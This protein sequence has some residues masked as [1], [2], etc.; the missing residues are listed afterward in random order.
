MLKKCQVLVKNKHCEL[1]WVPAENGQVPFGALQGGYTNDEITV[2]IGRVAYDGAT[3][4]GAVSLLDYNLIGGFTLFY[5]ILK[6][7]TR[8][9]KLFGHF[10]WSRGIAR[11]L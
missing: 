1:T 3:L 9:R 8:P 10:Q 7:S 2:F 11:S 4:I 5:T 6:G